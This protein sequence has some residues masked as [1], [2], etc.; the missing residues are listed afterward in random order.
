MLIL[1][2][3]SRRQTPMQNYP[4]GKELKQVL[5]FLEEWYIYIVNL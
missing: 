4:A 2:K 3:I 1:K 5:T